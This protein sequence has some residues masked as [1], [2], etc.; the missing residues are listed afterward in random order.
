[1]KYFLTACALLVAVCMSAIPASAKGFYLG[2]YGGWNKDDVTSAPFVDDN[3]GY[4]IGGVIGTKLNA[5]PGV[6]LEA[7]LSFRQNETDLFGGFISAD[8]DTTALMA[9][10]VWDVPVAIGPVHP[11]VLGGIG[12]AN[13]QAT[14]ENLAI[15]RL[16]ATG[17]AFQLGAGLNTEI[18]DGIT[19]GIGYRYFAGPELE[20]LGLEL[21]DGSN[22]SVVASVN[23]QFD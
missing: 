23:F 19:A 9:N 3:S 15:A 17:V 7:D 11:Y 4:V 5:V 18:A 6:R 14:F 12:I 13:T 16:E 1:M 10:V 21:S 8:H 20:V 2:T 22:H